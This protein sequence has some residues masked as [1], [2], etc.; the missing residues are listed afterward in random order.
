MKKSLAILLA[1]LMLLGATACDGG[2]NVRGTITGGDSSVP[3]SDDSSAPI[4]DEDSSTPEAGEKFQFGSTVGG[5]Y[6][7]TYIGIGCELDSQWTY[8]SDAEILAQNNLTMEYMDESTADLLENAQLIY[9]MMAIHSNGVN[10]VLVNL[11]KVTPLQ[12]VATDLNTMLEQ[13]VPSVESAMTN[14]GYTNFTWEVSDVTID[15]KTFPALKIRSEINGV[16]AYQ[17]NVSIKCAQHI[18]SLT[19]TCFAENDT[20]TILDSFY[21]LD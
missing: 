12:L 21:L 4:S 7:N 2:E 6:E 19:V 13:S 1:A 8:K 11:E 9:D 18:A 17:T 14:M 5:K 16:V 3:V 10:N 20:Q 15:G